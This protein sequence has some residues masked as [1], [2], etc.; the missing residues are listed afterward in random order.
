MGLS[1]GPLTTAAGLTEKTLRQLE[2]GRGNLDSWRAILERLGLELAGRNL[3]PGESL[4]T[5]LASLRRRRR[6]SQRELA[7]L[8]G[9]SPPTIVAL[10]GQGRGRLDTLERVLETLGACAY[11]T[12]RFPFA[13][14]SSG[15]SSS[16]PR[17]GILTTVVNEPSPGSTRPMNDSSWKLA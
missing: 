14:R 17:F 13:T 12:P 8:V 4:G 10:E 1:Q 5:R 11:L 2:Q 9:V 16:S 15:I 7:D 6:L 3:P